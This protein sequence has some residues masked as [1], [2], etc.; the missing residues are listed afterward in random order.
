MSSAARYRTDI[1]V[2]GAGAIGTA[3]ALELARQGADVHFAEKG[4]RWGSSVFFGG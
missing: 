3:I 4:A 2:V 1:T